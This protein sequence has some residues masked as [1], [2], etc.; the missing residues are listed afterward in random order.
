[1]KVRK[2]NI[3]LLVTFSLALSPAAICQETSPATATWDFSAFASVQTGEEITNSFGEAQIITAGFSA[4]RTVSR[5]IGRSWMRGGIEYAFSLTPLFV[6]VRPESLHGI[7]FE[8]LI[9]RWNSNHP[10]G[11]VTPYVELAGGGVHTNS[12]F[13]NGN[14]SSFNFTARGGAGI[15]LPAHGRNAF[16][17]GVFLVAHLERKLGSA[18][19]RVQRDGSS[20]SVPLVS[21]NGGAP[22]LAGQ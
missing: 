17:L 21:L 3:V 5:N 12:N 8:P 2:L 19:P 20:D 10:F 16:D 15:Y 6:Q 13:P 11:H 18:K 9:F 1:M 14:T 4:G 7:A 22:R